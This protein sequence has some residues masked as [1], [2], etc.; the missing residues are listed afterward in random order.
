MFPWQPMFIGQISKIQGSALINYSKLFTVHDLKAQLKPKTPNQHNVLSKSLIPSTK[1]PNRIFSV[2]W[3]IDLQLESIFDQVLTEGIKMTCSGCPPCILIKN[4]ILLFHYLIVLQIAF[5]SSIFLFLAAYNIPCCFQF[6]NGAQIF[7]S[8]KPY[9]H[10]IQIGEQ[11]GHL[12]LFVSRDG[13]RHIF[14]QV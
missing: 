5:W 7:Y 4:S 13:Y 8:S 10:M 3:Y 9:I 12:Q 6:I 2:K 11:G 1:V 14:L